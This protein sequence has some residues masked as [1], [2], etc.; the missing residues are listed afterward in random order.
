[1]LTEDLLITR[2]KLKWQCIA[3]NNFQSFSIRHS[4]ATGRSKSMEKKQSNKLS[5]KLHV[6]SVGIS[7]RLSH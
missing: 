6:V 5:N 1:M 3:W 4:M 7:S 2:R